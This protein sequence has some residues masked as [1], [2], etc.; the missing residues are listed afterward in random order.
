M[1]R[2]PDSL[3]LRGMHRAPRGS[4]RSLAVRSSRPSRSDR[5]R[6]CC[7]GCAD[8]RRLAGGGA[9]PPRDPVRPRD[10]VGSPPYCRARSNCASARRAAGFDFRSSPS[11]RLACLRSQSRLGESGSESGAGEVGSDMTHLLSFR[12]SSAVG[13]RKRRLS[14]NS[15]G[16]VEP[17]TR[18]VGRPRGAGRNITRCWERVKTRRAFLAQVR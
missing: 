7:P 11:R 2:A 4:R 13:A 6:A 10:G 16:R 3:R 17:F 1:R 5:C 12:P 18:T 14:A 8:R 9:R 15:R